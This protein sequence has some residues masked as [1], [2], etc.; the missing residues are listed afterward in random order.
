[1]LAILLRDPNVS[2]MEKNIMD[3]KNYLL[4][5]LKLSYLNYSNYIIFFLLENKLRMYSVAVMATAGNYLL[6][7]FYQ[8]NSA[9]LKFYY[10]YYCIG[11]ENKS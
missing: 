9:I 7:R 6:I 10:Y 5:P 3:G 8:V 2:R 1:M 11:D 4:S